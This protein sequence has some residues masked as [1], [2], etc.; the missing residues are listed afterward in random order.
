MICDAVDKS[1][2]RSDDGPMTDTF[3]VC[4][5]ESM[6]SLSGVRKCGRSCWVISSGSKAILTKILNCVESFPRIFL[7]FI[8]DPPD[9]IN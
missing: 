2:R 6:Y 4:L 7:F 9:T 8:S 5:W 1:P 3:L